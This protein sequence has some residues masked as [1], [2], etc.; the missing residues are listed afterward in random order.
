M[1][2]LC[3]ANTAAPLL[4][5]KP[6]PMEKTIATLKTGI[7]MQTKRFMP[8]NWGVKGNFDVSYPF[9]T[10]TFYESYMSIEV[11]GPRILMPSTPLIYELKYTNIDYLKKGIIYIRIFHHQSDISKYLYLSGIAGVGSIFREIS[12]IVKENN[13]PLKIK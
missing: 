1:T 13:L 10:I 6:Q 2:I 4:F 5:C 11:T 12:S 9:A 8:T 7:D 3:N